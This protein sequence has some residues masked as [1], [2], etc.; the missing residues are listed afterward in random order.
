V[1]LS[2]A[3]DATSLKKALEEESEAKENE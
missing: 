3:Q 2:T 1:Y